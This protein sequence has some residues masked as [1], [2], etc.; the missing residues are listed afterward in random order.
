MWGWGWGADYP[1]GENFV[2]QLYGKNAGDTNLSY[3]KNAEYDKYFEASV[4]LPD[5]AERTKLYDQ[6]TKIAVAQQPW[7]FGDTRLRNRLAHAHV[8]GYKVH[9]IMQTEWRYVDLQ[10]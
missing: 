5:G 8:Q 9:P 10:K 3:F 7:V 6:M 2:M 4:K 1:D